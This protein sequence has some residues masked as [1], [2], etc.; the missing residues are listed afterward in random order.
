MRFFTLCLMSSALLLGCQKPPQPTNTDKQT[1]QQ[2]NKTTTTQQ[3]C[4][5]LNQAMQN[6]DERSSIEALNQ[7][8]AQLKQ[9]I[10]QVKNTQQLQWL[11]NSSNMYLRFM[12]GHQ[13]KKGYDQFLNLEEYL[14]RLMDQDS[15]WQSIQQ[16]KNFQAKPELFKKLSPRDQ[17]LLQHRGQA[18]IE[19]QDQG[20]G[21]IDYR[22]QPQYILDV[23]A[24]SLPIDQK[25][26]V[27]RMAKDNQDLFY[28][29]AAINASWAELI[30]RALFWEK[31]LQQYPQSYF[32]KD[33]QRLLDEY[34]FLIFFGSDNTPAP[35]PY[36]GL[37]SDQ[38]TDKEALQQI[39]HL[40][41]QKNSHLAE[42]AQKYLAFTTTR[43]EQRQQKFALTT[44]NTVTDNP[45]SNSSEQLHELLPL[46]SPF[47]NTDYRDCH[48]DA[49]CI[50]YNIN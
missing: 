29:D 35:V 28:I 22:R 50:Q 30:E 42:V 48:Q 47:E 49:I 8:N 12:Q 27:Q 41:K 15:S 4:T 17:Y 10:S 5:N 34:S 38:E 44:A 37:A 21:I 23:F 39:Q 16:I 7:V 6:I 36:T 3:N 1:L 19:L 20:E 33:A 18:Y 11:Q 25:I 26:F 32:A 2:T 9:C 24:P 40:A 31:Y 13:S 46:K 14:Y 45:E 43:L